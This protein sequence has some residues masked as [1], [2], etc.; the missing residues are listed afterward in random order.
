MMTTATRTQTPTIAK[1][2]R[3]SAPFCSLRIL[4]MT[5]WR[6]DFTVFGDLATARLS[7]LRVET[8]A[9][10]TGGLV[11]AG[12][13]SDESVAVD[14]PSRGRTRA[15]RAAG[16]GPAGRV[17]QELV[18]AVRRGTR[19]GRGRSRIAAVSS[20]AAAGAPNGSRS[21]GSP[22]S[23]RTTA[24]RAPYPNR[25]AP[26]ARTSDAA[27]GPCS[28]GGSTR[29]ARPRTTANGRPPSL[30][31]AELGRPGDLVGDGGRGHRELVAVGVDAPGVAPRRPCSPAAPIAMSV[32]P[33]RQ[34]R[35]AVSV[36]ITATLRPVRC[37][38]PAR[39]RARRGVG[40]LGQQHDGAGG[41]VR[42]VD[43]GGG[44][45]QAVP[46]AHDR[47]LAAAG[48]DPDG[49]AGQRVLAGAGAD[50]ALGLAHDLAGH[51]HDVAVG[52]RRPAA[53]GSRPGR[54]RP[55]PRARRR[56]RSPR[57]GSSAPTQL[58]GGRGHRG[59]GVG[60]GHHQGYGAAGE[61]GG[62]RPGRPGRRRRVSTQ[63]AV[64]HAAV[65]R[66]RRSAGRPRRR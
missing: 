31:W 32:W 47:G 57:S 42:A 13:H 18:V 43:P 40:V 23:A 35:P 44:H 46:G 48:D 1:P 54:R 63:P 33:S 61:P 53:P 55:G 24:S 64:E 11:V 62:R 60:V 19:A 34:A 38:S 36:T 8:S 50:P 49:L 58:H 29:S 4:S 7:L 6:S 37:S 26:S 25:S 66:G 3:R 56:G 5:A 22:T 10:S 27:P 12:H 52:E 15:P 21:A 9:E 51:H 39:M 2:R 16:P 17:T 14:R 20:A 45:G 30:P 41:D 65:R 59:G 28:P